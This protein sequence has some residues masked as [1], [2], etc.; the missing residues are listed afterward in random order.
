MPIPKTLLDVQIIESEFLPENIVLF[1]S[2]QQLVICNITTG[3]MRT[4]ELP[5]LVERPPLIEPEAHTARIW[6]L[7]IP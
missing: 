4:I 2:G 3:E 5:R 7:R 6:R 1:K